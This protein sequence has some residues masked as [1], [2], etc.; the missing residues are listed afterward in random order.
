[1]CIEIA[2]QWIAI[3]NLLESVH[4]STELAEIWREDDGLVSVVPLLAEISN[5]L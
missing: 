4:D 1:M 3:L 2:Q 5:N